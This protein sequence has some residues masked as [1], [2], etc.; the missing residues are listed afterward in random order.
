MA[1]I[2]DIRHGMGVNFLAWRVLKVGLVAST[3][4]RVRIS[5]WVVVE[6][7]FVNG[8]CGV[9]ADKV[10]IPLFWSCVWNIE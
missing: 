7:V 1:R 4:F 9:S 2:A 6:V 10:R 5:L 3:L 8:P